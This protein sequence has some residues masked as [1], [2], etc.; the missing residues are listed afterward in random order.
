MSTNNINIKPLINQTNICYL[1][2]IIQCLFNCNL[3]KSIIINTKNPLFELL[4]NCYNNNNLLP[5]LHS[6]KNYN[7]FFNT[8]EQQD[9]HET[10]ILLLD[11]FHKLLLQKNIT[12]HKNLNQKEYQNIISYYKTFGYSP[13]NNLFQGQYITTFKCSNCSKIEYSYEM[14]SDIQIPITYNENNNN[15]NN[16]SIKDINEIL[17]NFFSENL[18]KNCEY[19]KHN[20]INFNKLSY[21]NIFPN[22]LILLLKRF[23]KSSIN[24][25]PNQIIYF[26]DNNNY[27]LNSLIIHKGNSIHSGHYYTIINLNNEYYILNDESIIK[28][29]FKSIEFNNIYLII[30]EKC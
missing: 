27:K 9:V 22:Y 3:I 4:I 20:N 18:T 17:T 28:I 16:R 1:N 5:F 11:I 7:S 12:L 15:M 2:S 21:I 19:C 10:F 13:I 8:F 23:D 30:Y 6:L 26:E 14:F 25:F 24:I 29:E